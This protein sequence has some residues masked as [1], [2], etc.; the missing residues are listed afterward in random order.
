MIC[1]SAPTGTEWG[2]DTHTT[3]GESCLVSVEDHNL[4]DRSASRF[5]RLKIYFWESNGKPNIENVK[6]H[7]KN[8]NSVVRD[9]I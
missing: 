2:P 7:L 5:R 9:T 6:G 3:G 1:T 4:T 8:N